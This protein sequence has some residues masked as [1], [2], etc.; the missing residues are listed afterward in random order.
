MQRPWG[1]SKP[2]VIKNGKE[3]LVDGAERMQGRAVG[4]EDR[5]ETGSRLCRQTNGS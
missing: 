2:R 5:E 4:D 3:A 1:C